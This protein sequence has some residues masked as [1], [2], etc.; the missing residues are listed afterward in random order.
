MGS[1]ATFESGV[2]E[3]KQT[4]AILRKVHPAEFP[5]MVGT[6]L[7]QRIRRGEN[8][9]VVKSIPWEMIDAD[10]CS[11]WMMG[12]K[13]TWTELDPVETPSSRKSRKSSDVQS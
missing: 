9:V 2:G 6:A 1:L 5:I 11:E 8:P 12:L 7:S 10:P 13:P 4:Y 3:M